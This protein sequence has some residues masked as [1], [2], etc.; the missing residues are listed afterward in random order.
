MFAVTGRLEYKT[1]DKIAFRGVLFVFDSSSKL[2]YNEVL[3][4]DAQAIGAFPTSDGKRQVLLVGGENRVWEYDVRQPG[5]A[6]GFIGPQ[7]G[8][9]AR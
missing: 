6:A 3:S 4:D 8:N 7:L 9:E 5:Y 2:I 1:F